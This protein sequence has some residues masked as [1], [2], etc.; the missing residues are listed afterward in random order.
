[1]GAQPTVSLDQVVRQKLCAVCERKFCTGCS[2][3]KKDRAKAV[4]SIEIVKFVKKFKMIPRSTSLGDVSS[5]LPMAFMAPYLVPKS[6]PGSIIASALIASNEIPGDVS[7]QFKP[8]QVSLLASFQLDAVSQH[9]HLVVLTQM[10]FIAGSS[11]ASE[12]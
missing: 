11:R 1:M 2:S 4:K 10:I 3:N 5:K 6:W 9:F 12:C 8:R 7:C